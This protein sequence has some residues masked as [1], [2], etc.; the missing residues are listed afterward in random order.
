MFYY[1]LAGIVLGVVGTIIF[2]KRKTYGTVIVFYPDDPAEPPCLGF[3]INR[4]S[5]D[6]CKQKRVEFDVKVEQLNSQK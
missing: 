6:I 4:N 3:K 5:N 1:L 2:T